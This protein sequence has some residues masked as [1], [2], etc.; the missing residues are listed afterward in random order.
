MKYGVP[1]V[2]PE[3]LNNVE[4]RIQRELLYPPLASLGPG[5]VFR[6]VVETRD[7]RGGAVA[8]NFRKVDR[9]AAA[10]RACYNQT[11]ERVSGPLNKTAVAQS[12]VPRVLPEGRRESKFREEISYGLVGKDVVIVT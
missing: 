5:G 12:E 7:S 3:L 6:R 1:D 9:R 2:G 8:D 4:R 11:A 10:I